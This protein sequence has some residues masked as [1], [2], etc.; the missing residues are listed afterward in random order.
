MLKAVCF[1]Q[2]PLKHLDL[3]VILPKRC[4]KQ[5]L[6]IDAT[7]GSSPVR[8]KASKRREDSHGNC[9]P[10]NINRWSHTPTVTAF[11]ISTKQV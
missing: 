3:S 5:L 8:K 9:E 2:I 6:H 7:Y 11:N 10:L 1:H 4:W